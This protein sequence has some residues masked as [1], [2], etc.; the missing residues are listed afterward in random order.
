MLDVGMLEEP[1]HAAIPSAA[2]TGT[3][4]L[5]EPLI[6]LLLFATKASEKQI[7]GSTIE[8]A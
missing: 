5:T 8:R 4:S 6:V 3:I 7:L 2:S 1:L